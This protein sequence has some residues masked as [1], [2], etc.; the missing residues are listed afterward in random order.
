VEGIGQEER[1]KEGERPK[2]GERVRVKLEVHKGAEKAAQGE[3]FKG[4]GEGTKGHEKFKPK[5]VVPEKQEEPGEMN[6]ADA[7]NLLKKK[8]SR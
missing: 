8:F 3:R 7:L 2:E 6:M 4:M 5:V 1:H